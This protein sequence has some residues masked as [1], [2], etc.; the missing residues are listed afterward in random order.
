[1]VN[2]VLRF[3]LACM[4]AG[5]SCAVAADDEALHPLSQPYFRGLGAEFLPERPEDLQPWLAKLKQ[6]GFNSIQTL[7]LD[8]LMTAPK[9]AACHEAGLAVFAY[10]S[11]PSAGNWLTKTPAE[12]P[13][14]VDDLKALIDAGFDGVIFDF[15]TWESFPKGDMDA[16][17]WE[18]AVA[19]FNRHTQGTWTPDA[20]AEAIRQD[21]GQFGREGGITRSYND[22][23]C[24]FHAEKAQRLAEVAVAYAKEKG[25]RFWLGF[26]LPDTAML[27][28]S[29]RL[30]D[31]ATPLMCPMLYGPVETGN[32]DRMRG[33]TNHHV[34]PRPRHSKALVCIEAGFPDTGGRKALPIVLRAIWSTMLSHADGY[35]L[36]HAAFATEESELAI[37]NLNTIGRLVFDPLIQEQP[38]QARR[39]LDEWAAFVRRTVRK[40]TDS[41]LLRWTELSIKLGHLREKLTP[42]VRYPDQLPG[43]VVEPLYDSALLVWEM[44]KAE[45]ITG[46]RS[47]ELAPFAFDWRED[48]GFLKVSCDAL[49]M[50]LWQDNKAGNIDDLRIQGLG[51][52]IAAGSRGDWGFCRL[53]GSF[54]EWGYRSHNAI[55]EQSAARV[56]VE[57]VLYHPAAVRTVRTTTFELGD[58]VIKV[59][60]RFINDG[61]EP[62][63]VKPR[64]W[65]CLNLGPGQALEVKEQ[66]GTRYAILRKA[67]MFAVIAAATGPVDYTSNWGSGGQRD[68]FDLQSTWELAPGDTKSLRFRFA[69]GRGGDAKLAPILDSLTG[70]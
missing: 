68:L 11:L 28:T 19:A 2:H 56:V 25:K 62:A 53:R 63:R 38:E 20:L 59:D 51:K 1:M 37:A 12:D 31:R 34:P 24:A 58:P 33:D 57:T 13:S 27:G 7:A 42:S 41:Q 48:T 5:A 9:V 30:L 60:F 21:E 40:G 46:T 44:Q 4:F 52:N 6:R 50:A 3:M 67:D 23:R 70:Q 8:P 65:N 36:W 66:D 26:Y 16:P 69:V 35:T 15:A 49:G 45:L 17:Y 29:Y 18:A 32:P 54:D 64:L 47:F 55:V 22:F 10:S 39:G 14:R 61:G 43:H